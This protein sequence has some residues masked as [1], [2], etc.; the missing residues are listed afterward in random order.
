[1]PI[2]SLYNIK[3]GDRYTTDGNDVWIVDAI[4]PYPSVT[5]RQVTSP[6][7]GSDAPDACV[8]ASLDAAGFARFHPLE[9]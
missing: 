8:D 6:S 2:D 9:G 1:M 5:L 4:R 3:L 7:A